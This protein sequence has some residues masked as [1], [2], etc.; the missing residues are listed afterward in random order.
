MDPIQV[1]F[2]PIGFEEFLSSQINPV[3]VPV[4]FEP[5]TN[6]VYLDFLYQSVTYRQYWDEAGRAALKAAFARYEEDYTAKN[7]PRKRKSQTTR[8]Y[9][10]IT[11]RTDWGTIK[12]TIN[13]RSFPRFDFGYIFVR[14]DGQD[15]PYFIITQKSA[16]N[17][18]KVVSTTEQHDSLQIEFYLTR[19]MVEEL[20]ALFD[21]DNL[22]ALIPDVVK[23]RAE[24]IEEGIVPDEY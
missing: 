2:V 10:N 8:T 1:G 18:R 19:A 24:R 6:M 21:Q 22:L 3:D 23:E 17:V 16:P 4:F 14:T 12:W 11:G 9:G 5:R 13:S 15:S 7:L 20:L